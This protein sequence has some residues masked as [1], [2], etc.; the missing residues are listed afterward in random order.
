MSLAGEQDGVASGEIVAAIGSGENDQ[1]CSDAVFFCLVA[2]YSVNIH[3]PL[4]A[5]KK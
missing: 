5:C 3:P 4:K 2:F 1:A